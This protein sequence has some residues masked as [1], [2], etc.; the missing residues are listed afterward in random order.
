MN[1]GEWANGL[2]VFQLARPLDRATPT[3][4]NHVPFSMALMRRHGDLVRAD[5]ASGANELITMSGH[6]GTHVDALSHVAFNGRLHG[7]IDASRSSVGGRFQDHGIEAL[8]ALVCPAV[9]LDVAG[10]RGVESLQGDQPVT[11][12]LLAQTAAAQDVEVPAGGAALIRTG[13]GS[14]GRYDDPVA[15]LGWETGVPGP[16]L[17]ASQW[18]ADKRVRLAASDTLVFEHV[19]PGAGHSSLPVHTHLIYEHGIHIAELLDL[20][21]LAESRVYSFALVIAPLRMLGATGSPVTPLAL[22]RT[23]NRDIV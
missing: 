17:S 18:L 13:W 1:G 14:G 19:P 8:G 20:D 7:G 2:T 10:F 22:V 23:P 9:L 15:F 12:D 11:A 6:T 4:P 21:E 3:T 16:D 5:G